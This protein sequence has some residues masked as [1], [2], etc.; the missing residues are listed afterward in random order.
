MI[1]L[2]RTCLKWFLAKGNWTKARAFASEVITILFTEGRRKD[3][4]RVLKRIRGKLGD[5]NDP[6]AAEMLDGLAAVLADLRAA[7]KK[8][9]P[10]AW[11]R[12]P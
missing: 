11:R 1:A 9:R 5:V 12:R 8:E 4:A 2:S 10:A 6:A 3:A 7:R